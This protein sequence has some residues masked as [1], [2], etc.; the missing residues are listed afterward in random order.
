MEAPLNSDLRKCCIGYL[1]A[2][3]DVQKAVGVRLGMHVPRIA[4][5][6]VTLWGEVKGANYDAEF[7]NTI[8]KLIVQLLCDL[9]EKHPHDA[10]YSTILLPLKDDIGEWMDGMAH[11]GESS[12]V[13]NLFLSI[14]SHGELFHL[15]KD[16]APN[17]LS[18]IFVTR[19]NSGKCLNDA[20][21]LV[22][23]LLRGGSEAAGLF[24]IAEDKLARRGVSYQKATRL[25][26]RRIRRQQGDDRED[27][28]DDGAELRALEEEYSDALKEG[29]GI[30]K[31]HID[32]VLLSI[33]SSEL[34]NAEVLK[35]LTILAPLCEKEA[36]ASTLVELLCSQLDT[37]K[38][39]D[40]R[41]QDVAKAAASI[42]D[43]LVNGGL[44][45]M[46][47]P[48]TDDTTH[49]SGVLTRGL[50]TVAGLGTRHQIALALAVVY[51]R[52]GR[53]DN[54]TEKV[55][56]LLEQLTAVN[57]LG[58]E[59][60]FDK[61]VDGLNLILGPPSDGLSA[62]WWVQAPVLR[63]MLWQLREPTCDFGVRRLIEDAL[64]KC[65]N[66]RSEDTTVLALVR[67]LIIPWTRKL[68]DH[69][70]EVVV[71]SGI[72]IIAAYC[73]N[74]APFAVAQGWDR[75]RGAGS[76]TKDESGSTWADLLH[77][78]LMPLAEQGTLDDL[79]HLQKSRQHKALVRILALEDELSKSTI[80][81]LLLPLARYHIT[82]SPD[83]HNLVD[84]STGIMKLAAKD[85]S[86][87]RVIGIFR[88]LGGQL[89]P[90]G[91]S[92]KGLRNRGIGRHG[93]SP[94]QMEKALL[95]GVSA[96]VQG[97]SQRDDLSEKIG[98]LKST[99]LPMLRRLVYTKQK[100]E[101]EAGAVGNE[102]QAHHGRGGQ[103][104]VFVTI[105]V[106]MVSAMLEVLSLMDA[107]VFGSE[108]NKLTGVVVGGLLSREL[109]DR[110]KARDALSRMAAAA[111]S[112]KQITFMLRTIRTRMSR[113]GYQTPVAVFTASKIID[114]ATL[115]D[116]EGVESFL[117]E[118]MGMYGMEEARWLSMQGRAEST[119][120][121]EENPMLAK[122]VSEAARPKANAILEAVGKAMPIEKVLDGLMKPLYGRLIGTE[123]D[124]VR[125]GAWSSQHAGG[126]GGARFARRVRTSMLQLTTGILASHSPIQQCQRI[127]T[128][129]VSVLED[130][131]SF[132]EVDLFSASAAIIDPATSGEGA[133]NNTRKSRKEEAVTVLPGA[134]TG[135]GAWVAE[136]WKKG[137]GASTR[138]YDNTI[139]GSA[140]AEVG[141]KLL[142]GLLK[143]GSSST[144][145][146][147]S[148]EETL[149]G[150][151][152][153]IAYF[154]TVSKVDDVFVPAARSLSRLIS[155][156][157]YT[158]VKGGPLASSSSSSSSSTS[159]NNPLLDV[160]SAKET[161]GIVRSVLKMV[162][163]YSAGA[164]LSKD[165]TV[166]QATRQQSTHSSAASS[167]VATCTKLLCSLLTG[168][169]GIIKCNE[170]LLLALLAHV[171]L[172]VSEHP[173]LRMSAM[174]MLRRVIMPRVSPPSE[175]STKRT[176][177]SGKAGHSQLVVQLYSVC[178]VVLENLLCGAGG[179]Y[180]NDDALGALCGQIV[181]KWLIDYP[182]TTQSLTAKIASLV[183][184][185]AACANSPNPTC[186]PPT[187][188]YSIN[189]LHSL[190]LQ[191]PAEVLKEFSLMMTLTGLAG[192][193][194]ETDDRCR[195]M[196]R[197]L[198]KVVVEK[199]HLRA[200]L[201]GKVI[202]WSKADQPKLLGAFGEFCLTCAD[203]SDAGIVPVLREAVIRLG[204]ISSPQQLT[205]WH[206]LYEL[207][208]AFEAGGYHKSAVL[209]DTSN[210]FMQLSLGPAGTQAPHPWVR[211]AALRIVTEYS[212]GRSEWTIPESAIDS[213]LLT[214]FGDPKHSP[215]TDTYVP[216]GAIP[217]LTTACYSPFAGEHP[218]VASATVRATVA[219]LSCA[220][221]DQN[222]RVE[223]VS[224]EEEVDEEEPE[225]VE[226]DDTD[227]GDTEEDSNPLADGKDEK[228]DDKTS[229]EDDDEAD[230]E[231]VEGGDMGLLVEHE[232]DAVDNGDLTMELPPESSE[233][234][235]PRLRWLLV[236]TSYETR[237]LLA[238]YKRSGGIVRLGALLKLVCASAVLVTPDVLCSDEAGLLKPLLSTLVRIS[239]VRP[240]QEGED[241]SR[242]RLLPSYI[243][244][245]YSSFSWSSK[246]S[247]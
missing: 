131:C 176:K 192:A 163:F 13:L 14:A 207:L 31:E 92:R 111:T 19:G 17:F 244:Y 155:S 10:D 182:H 235:P 85:L 199:V 89:K 56:G 71:N 109:E 95:K 197:E 218:E 174:T 161:L 135:R 233:R 104:D 126:V 62:W 103:Q 236:R 231:D 198:V 116:G 97:I 225:E 55:S 142:E 164:S 4:K 110:R 22:T 49:V 169:V 154:I 240:A 220:Q 196:L 186:A 172:C 202:S 123:L 105:R 119:Q 77:V 173:K 40:K 80:S 219:V 96:A 84:V 150:I 91:V 70:S 67:G 21:R 178:N 50:S 6:L 94:E 27:E 187:R 133:S 200:T 230:L 7:T 185:A 139:R 143:K 245:L 144:A 146:L 124:D 87:T 52:M 24:K 38:G 32:E 238:A 90:G 86:W 191:M 184:V 11:A 45:K 203:P 9:L 58:G 23:L 100:V 26:R 43:T 149:R 60:D 224:E 48:P 30:I 157:K 208:I 46:W 42:L 165:L 72:R 168:T 129:A 76:S 166:V 195:S 190:A 145:S 122:Q 237:K 75:E 118:V 47:T 222:S 8:R 243:E 158:S 232:K 226:I 33:G 18:M 210:A 68:L 156:M 127:L 229:S 117:K 130:K 228:G 51:R 41:P 193:A 69:P 125:E 29:E 216:E 177:N 36:T 204:Q 25:R 61:Q 102:K 151:L 241:Q 181:S 79:F 121:T 188:R 108:F 54:A 201:R 206:T 93:V 74:M 114:S 148:D 128:R 63:H 35:A 234:V 247:Y 171:E 223:V 137:S 99:V 88:W 20:C 162:Q 175:A 209:D 221:R 147:L 180:Y 194:G 15:F 65:G 78:E 44:L 53:T 3:K 12:L 138:R 39:R 2:L 141:L 246:Q 134:A 1:K 132:E 66:D 73:T 153:P 5:R 57:K 120:G 159:G 189:A 16:L 239:S 211:L 112:L 227:I 205:Y 81:H 83:D 101:D 115:K 98:N 59:P 82:N 217:R 113:G 167:I 136:E 64:C 160:L 215:T 179:T 106:S 170:E 152:S 213:E 107:D 140:A 183:R 214:Q 28:Q 212:N 34:G 37:L 242:G